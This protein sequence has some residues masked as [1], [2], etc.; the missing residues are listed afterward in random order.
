MFAPLKLE[1]VSM[2]DHIFVF[3]HYKQSPLHKKHAAGVI[4]TVIMV[5]CE[6]NGMLLLSVM[7]STFQI[8][9]LECWVWKATD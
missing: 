2:C 3:Y 5:C 9:D 1:D 6:A 8:G 7:K 4:V